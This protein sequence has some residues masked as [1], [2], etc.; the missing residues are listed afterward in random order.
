MPD[1][2]TVL[3]EAV[4]TAFAAEGVDAA[5]ARVTPSDRPDLADFQSNG[6]L[7]AA[8]A[9]KANPRE[10][11]TR[12][13][14]HLSADPRFTSVEVAG[15]GFINLKLADAVLAERATEVAND[16]AHAGAAVV[17][18]PRKVII[19]FGGPNV[20]KPMHVGHLRSAII[21]E[22]LKRLFRFRGDHVTGD[23]HFGD[24]GFQMGLLITACGDAG[25][26]VAV[27]AV[28]DGPFPGACP[29]TLTDLDRLYP[30]A[31]G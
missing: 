27:M 25:V 23:A 14:E 16:A 5:L 3:G 22:S 21:G 12:I 9:L 15:P 31:A 28:G 1:L 8:K 26:A 20:A 18:E 6:A 13:A 11:A 19:D 30:L 24:W 2:K 10:L 7:A 17:A 29:V 4:A